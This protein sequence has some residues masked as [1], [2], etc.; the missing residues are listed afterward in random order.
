MGSHIPFIFQPDN[1][2][3]NDLYICRFDQNDFDFKEV[4]PG[5]YDMTLKI[6]ETW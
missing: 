6:I 4:A 3:F 2:D 5:L 1:T